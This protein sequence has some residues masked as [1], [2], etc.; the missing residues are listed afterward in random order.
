MRKNCKNS[1][2]ILFG[3]PDE[4]ALVDAVLLSWSGYSKFIYF[5]G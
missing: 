2:Q 4:N 3:I 5:Y 1:K